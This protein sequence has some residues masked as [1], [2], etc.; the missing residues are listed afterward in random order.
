MLRIRVQ[1]LGWMVEDTVFGLIA[2]R[3]KG[4]PR[5][6]LR[7]LES[8][9]MLA[10]SLNEEVVREDHFH[11]TCQIESID[12]RGLTGNEVRYLKILYE[13]DD[14]ARLNI[15]GSRLGLNPKHV[16]TIIEQ[17]LIREGLVTKNNSVR[18]LT[19]DGLNHLREFHNDGE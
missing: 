7:L 1:Q 11:R 8:V 2:Q 6:A 18:V 15:L 9:R 5:I 19:Q 16:S 12:P 13:N 17:F 10:S 3:G 4:V 14:S